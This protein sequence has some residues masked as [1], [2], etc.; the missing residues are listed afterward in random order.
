MTGREDCPSCAIEGQLRPHVVWFGELPL[1]LDAIYQLLAECKLFL[2]IGTS[3]NVEPAASFVE[4]AR[5]SGA[6]TVE[7]NL[8]PSQ[9]ADLFAERIYGPATT[10]VAD[11]VKKLIIG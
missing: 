9:S 6:H 4:E 10:I 3:G 7:L 8:E 2:A 5:R 1:R 11:Y